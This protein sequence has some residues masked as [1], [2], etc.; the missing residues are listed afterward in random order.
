[1]FLGLWGRMRKRRDEKRKEFER[2]QE[3]KRLARERMLKATFDEFAAAREDHRQRQ[4]QRDMD[5]LK[6]SSLD[7]RRDRMQGVLTSR[8]AEVDDTPR[9]VAQSDT[10]MIAAQNFIQSVQQSSSCD[11]GSSYSDTS[12]S[13]SSSDCGSSSDSG[14]G[15]SCGCD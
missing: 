6:V 13:S 8:R 12:S 4:F 1:M 15:G 9:R 14:G 5:A 10:D 2:L 3:E 7:A 11:G